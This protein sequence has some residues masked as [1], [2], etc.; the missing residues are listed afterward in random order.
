MIKALLF[1]MDGVVIDSN[2]HHRD[3]WVAYNGSHGIATTEAM[4]GRMYGKRN[5]EIVRD[6][7]GGH[8]TEE[9]ASR[10]GAGKE[11]LFREMVSSKVQS[12]LVPGVHE[13]L[14]QH[15]NFAI[16]LATNAEAANADF[17]LERTGL[18]PL[19]QFVVDGHQV[20]HAKPHPEIYLRA[21]ELLGVNPDECVVFEDSH[22]GVAAGIAAGMPVIGITTTHQDLPGTVFSAQSFEDPAISAYLRAR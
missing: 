13:F 16:A 19:F 18:R 3:A 1:D 14:R 21:A 12:L 10:H 9:E 17:V 8:L 6:F 15:Q 4:L 7:F 22:A 11:A 20:T 2:G 5:D